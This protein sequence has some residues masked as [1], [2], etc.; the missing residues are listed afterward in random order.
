MKPID[1]PSLALLMQN[2]RNGDKASYHQFLERITPIFRGIIRAKAGGLS[3]Q[4][5]ED[6]L[7]EIIF[8]VHNK[9]ATWQESQPIKPWLYAIARYKIIDQFRKRGQVQTVDIDQFKD[10]IPSEEVPDLAEPDV[11][12]MVQQIG[13]KPELVLRTVS[14]EGQSFSEAAQTLKMSPSAIRVNFHRGLTKLREIAREMEKS[15]EN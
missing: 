12:N 2:G 11:E 1:E 9:R 4:D 6:I 5:Q 10:I 15:Y 3:V 7:Q 14:L 8:A 13:G